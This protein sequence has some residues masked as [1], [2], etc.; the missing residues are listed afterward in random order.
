MG[1]T[2]KWPRFKEHPTGS[3][4]NGQLPDRI[5]AP[6]GRVTPIG[7]AIP[8]I[9]RELR[10]ARRYE[11]PLGILVLTL[12][13]GFTP[14]ATRLRGLP[15]TKP[16]M[17]RGLSLPADRGTT[18]NGVAALGALLS[19]SIRETDVL[20]SPEGERYYLLALPETGWEAMTLAA[21][22][23]ARGILQTGQPRLRI[24][25]AEFPS[26]GLTLDELFERARREW[27]MNPL[28]LD[29]PSNQEEAVH[30]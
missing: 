6:T 28:P 26:Q 17:R 30:A 25:M 21:Q 3:G 18:G 14:D 9:E 29:G 15:P 20:T 22:R 4:R 11:H 13:D 27:L 24:G 10:R 1:F 2:L 5:A 8:L 19:H 12:A 7:E 23:I 16:R